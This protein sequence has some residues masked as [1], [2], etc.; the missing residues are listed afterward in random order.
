[1]DK[2]FGVFGAGSGPSVVVH[3]HQGSA[4][5]VDTLQP[6]WVVLYDPS[7]AAIRNLEVYSARHRDWRTKVY[8]LGHA[9]STEQQ[10]SYTELNNEVKAFKML[11][12]A[13]ASLPHYHVTY[14]AGGAQP[15]GG[16]GVRAPKSRRAG[17]LLQ[18]LSA[19]RRVLV[20]LREF[21]SKL[22]SGL[23]RNGLVPVPVHLEVADYVLSPDIGVERKSL[24]DLM[25][26]LA[27]GRL[28]QQ[29][30]R[31]AKRYPVPVLL[32][33][34]EAGR[35]FCMTD[36]VKWNPGR[37]VFTQHSSHTSLAFYTPPTP[38]E[39]TRALLD[40]LGSLAVLCPTL[41]IWWSRG[42][43]MSARLFE[44]AKSGRQDPDEGDTSETVD[45]SADA[46]AFLRRLP[47]VTE[48][49]I[50]LIVESFD[51]IAD[52][53]QAAPDRLATMLGEAGLHLFRALHDS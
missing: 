41:R 31:L 28:L 1:M 49:N 7:I 53:T 19:N 5:L 14:G 9:D 23:H 39:K 38:E 36:T 40:K 26:S 21:R 35:Q 8:V 22:P 44:A 42:Q 47:G 10:R 17:G 29:V 30:E 52:L 6:T 46:I 18:T 11:A 24:P 50:T 33:E 34:F 43:D 2:Y 32:I 20:D 4:S 48:Q 45:H 3:T 25:G 16:G 37:E 12:R 27:S 13:R 15:A 51:T